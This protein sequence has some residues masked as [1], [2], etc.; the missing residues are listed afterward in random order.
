MYD[1]YLSS[2]AFS[3]CSWQEFCQDVSV[4]KAGYYLEASEQKQ[5]DCKS[6]ET[7]FNYENCLQSFGENFLS[8]SSLQVRESVP[9]IKRRRMEKWYDIP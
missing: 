4:E 1:P 2:F 6:G 9:S 8:S 3:L 7:D 5:L